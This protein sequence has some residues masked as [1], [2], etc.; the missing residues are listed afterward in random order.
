MEEDYEYE[1]L[2]DQAYIE[3]EMINRMNAEMQEFEH[4]SKTNKLPAKIE[5]LIKIPTE[6]GTT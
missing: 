1:Y 3:A 2:R 4:Y 5:V 6:H